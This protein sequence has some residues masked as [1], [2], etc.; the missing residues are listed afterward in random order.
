[1]IQ[2]TEPVASNRRF[3]LDETREIYHLLSKRAASTSPE[4]EAMPVAS[5]APVLHCEIGSFARWCHQVRGVAHTS[6]VASFAALALAF[7]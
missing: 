4:F 7:S 6:T 2:Q 3:Q 1:M 5:S